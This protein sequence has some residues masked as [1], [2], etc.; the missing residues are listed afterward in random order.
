[1]HTLPVSHVLGGVDEGS[2]A[3]PKLVAALHTKY[4]PDDELA[5]LHTGNLSAVLQVV[6]SLASLHAM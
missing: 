6:V 4:E 5:N 3:V 1:M 2:H